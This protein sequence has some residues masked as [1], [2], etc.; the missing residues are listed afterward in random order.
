MPAMSEQAAD[1]ERT[2]HAA[3]PDTPAAAL[4][5]SA[6]EA[7]AAL[8]VDERTVRRAIA[9]GELPAIKRA[10]S[11]QIAPAALA[12]YQAQRPAGRH[13]RPPAVPAPPRLVPLARPE[14]DQ[15]PP[16]PR[17]LTPLIGRERDLA[18]IT[19]ELAREDV[20]LLTLTGPGGVGKTRLTLAVAADVEPAFTDGVWLVD[21]APLVDPGLV[22]PTVAR[23][24]GVREASD[25][26]L[27]DILVARLRGRRLLLVLDN[28]EQVVVA[29]PDVAALLRLCP[30][31]KT[32]V[33]SREPLRVHGEHRYPVPPLDLPERPGAN[34]SPT[35][36]E[37]RR[38]GAVALFSHRA[39]AHNPMFRL[40]DATAADVAEVC[41]SGWT[42][43]RWR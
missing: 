31:A 24:L 25:R 14:P 3:A 23:A 34:T 37:L 26:P 13:N 33:T 10:G 22:L 9:R 27:R 20:R 36:D 29:A 40:D 16:L 21:L 43:C 15:P 28:F 1:P 41:A 17:P 4:P 6:R 39:Q 12:A 30:E 35:A 38:F 19:A 5:L 11:Y 32:L 2:G 18:A 42:G 8:G 7:A